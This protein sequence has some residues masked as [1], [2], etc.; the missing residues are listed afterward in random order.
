LW[1]ILKKFG[2]DCDIN[3]V[4]GYKYLVV[5][6]RRREM[7]LVVLGLCKEEEKGWSSSRMELDRDGGDGELEEKGK[8]RRKRGYGQR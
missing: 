5:L 2:V 6:Q 1:I 4:L 7:T 8:R 3:L